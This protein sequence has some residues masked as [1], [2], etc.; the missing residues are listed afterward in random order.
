M[1]KFLLIILVVALVGG[2]IWVWN[3]RSEQFVVTDEPSE[4][5][6]PDETDISDQSIVGIPGLIVIDDPKSGQTVSEPITLSG[7]ARGY[8][9]FEATAP[10]TV[11]NWDGLILG[12]GYITAE[13]DWMTEDFVPFTGELSF[14]PE[15]T[16]YSATGT[17]IF[18]KANAS[19]LPE[20]DRAFEMNVILPTL[21]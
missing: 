12:E 13:G 1:N 17:L 6:E 10:V 18:S 21:E 3:S 5:S 11:T 4:T 7:E 14:T 16:T 9:F 8:W 15:I 20:H 2:A 19:G